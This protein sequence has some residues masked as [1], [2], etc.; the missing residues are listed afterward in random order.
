MATPATAAPHSS[1]F[2]D[3]LQA[4]V[5]DPSHE[6]IFRYM[7]GTALDAV[8]DNDV[9]GERVAN[10]LT[11]CLLL[12]ASVHTLD[13][14]AHALAQ[15]PSP[16]I[17]AFVN[18]LVSFDAENLEVRTALRWG[19]LPVAAASR[20][21]VDACLQAALSGLQKQVTGA[22]DFLHRKVEA[23]EPATSLAELTTQLNT[24]LSGVT[25]IAT[26]WAVALGGIGGGGLHYESVETFKQQLRQA[27][28]I[29]AMMEVFHHFQQ[30]TNSPNAAMM[31]IDPRVVKQELKEQMQ[32]SE[33]LFK[34]VFDDPDFLSHFIQKVS[35]KAGFPA[36]A[37][38]T[39]FDFVPLLA[40]SP[41]FV[42]S[43]AW[44]RVLA[45]FDL[46]STAELEARLFEALDGQLQ[47]RV[48]HAAAFVSNLWL[49]L[50]G[51]LF[52]IHELEARATV[53]SGGSGEGVVTRSRSSLTLT[54]K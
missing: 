27:T 44:Q 25:D 51:L 17:K 52:A 7:T 41:K 45:L 6:R 24:L 10:I 54:R 3:N 5:S 12:P 22:V 9:D 35:A 32:H 42:I 14:T 21:S 37:S 1:A 53:S 39:I 46:G 31:I 23:S 19:A 2:L 11:S 47:P 8:A 43:V 13:V 4:W 28:S 20:P 30:L 16:A 34:R 18:N 49:V 38:K 26:S 29:P 40:K 33:S 48:E 36:T 15:T 50:C